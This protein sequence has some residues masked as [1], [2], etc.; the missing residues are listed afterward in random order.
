[1]RVRLMLSLVVVALAIGPVPSHAQQSGAVP[2]SYE[3]V[4]VAG[5]PIGLSAGTLTVNGQPVDHCS[6][7]LEGGSIRFRVDGTAP[8]ASD[9]Q[10]VTPGQWIDV[11]G[12]SALAHFRAI[13]QTATNGLIRFTCYWK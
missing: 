11:S 3:L 13:E 5:T 10:P 4:T 12:R 2:A 6:G 8:S 9:G 7:S 1:M